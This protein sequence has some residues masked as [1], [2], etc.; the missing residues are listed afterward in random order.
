M[1]LLFV[2][3]QMQYLARQVDTR[4]WKTSCCAYAH[5]MVAA[6]AARARTGLGGLDGGAGVIRRW[7]GAEPA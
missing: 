3:M 4:T 6:A 5:A 2:I 7:F 1:A